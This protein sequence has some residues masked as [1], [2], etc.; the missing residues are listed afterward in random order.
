LSANSGLADLGGPRDITTAIE[1]WRATIFIRRG[2]VMPEQM[3]E[4]HSPLAK[5]LGGFSGATVIEVKESDGGNTDR[6]VYTVRYAN[7]VY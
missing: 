7:T 4:R 5:T 2:A 1:N 6:A 3:G